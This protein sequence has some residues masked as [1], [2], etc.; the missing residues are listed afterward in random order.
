MSSFRM[1]PELPWCWTSIAIL[2]GLG[3]VPRIAR[4]QTAPPNTTVFVAPSPCHELP[5]SGGPW[6]DLLRVELAA[7]HIPVRFAPDSLHDP[8]VSIES[9][10]CDGPVTSATLTFVSGEVRRTR[11]VGLTDVDPVARPR[12]LAIAMADLVRAGVAAANAVVPTPPP[13][14]PT[15]EVRIEHEQR[16]APLPVG[17]SVEPAHHG[18][19]GL[20]A[21]GETRLFAPVSTGVFGARAGVTV[22]T[23]DW[24]LLVVDGG[25]FSGTG[26]D[27]LGDIVG[28]IGTVGLSLQGRGGPKGLSLAAGPRIEAGLG[29]FQGH[30]TNPLVRASSAT[31]PVV[32]VGVSTTGSFPIAGP[33]SGLVG[34]DAGTSLYGFT[35]AADQRSVSEFGGAMVSLRIGFAWTTGPR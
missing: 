29:W 28:T 34:L 1:L 18:G 16:Q 20:F 9:H 32:F 3:A 31:S 35:G 7:D 30:A 15:L 17:A 10:P 26:H 23:L 21:A 11:T 33:F 14:P 2:L 22:P 8:H 27:T 12:V 13:V 24:L 25:A 4:A 19:L 5:S 6:V